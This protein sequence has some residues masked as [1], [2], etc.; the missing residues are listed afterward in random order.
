MFGGITQGLNAWATAED[1]TR[2]RFI[3]GLLH[4]DI[5]LEVWESVSSKKR[6]SGLEWIRLCEGI[7]ESI[8][9]AMLQAYVGL[10]AGNISKDFVLSFSV[11]TSCLSSAM[12][13]V[14]WELYRIRDFRGQRVSFNSTFFWSLS[15]FRFAEVSTRIFTLAL[16]ATSFGSFI[17]II[18]ALELVIMVFMRKWVAEFHEGSPFDPLTDSL[19]VAPILFVVFYNPMMGDVTGSHRLMLPIPYWSL[20]FF[21]QLLIFILLETL[22]K[23]DPTYFIYS[24]IA[25]LTTFITIAISWN[26][27]NR[28]RQEAEEK[29]Y[30]DE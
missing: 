11:F 21:E 20:R 2:L 8:P 14:M 30:N 1:K 15:L 9:M 3:L 13:L 24:I 17:F 7:F 12:A 23:P 28:F 16:F 6:T 10:K 27:A 25:S 5:V 26:A 18:I 19:V 22:S 29:Q 4:L